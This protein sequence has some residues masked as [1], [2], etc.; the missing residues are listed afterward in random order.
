MACCATNG[1]MWP[2]KAP[3]PAVAL[4]L[5]VRHPW[6]LCGSV[7]APSGFR[8]TPPGSDDH[9][10]VGDSYHLSQAVQCRIPRVVRSLFRVARLRVLNVVATAS[11]A[12]E[13]GA[14]PDKSGSRRRQA[15]QRVWFGPCLSLIRVGLAVSQK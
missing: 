8:Q 3:D 2:T 10:D 9:E 13:V 5:L 1:S 12:G 14:E 7:A 11:K 6:M 4:L 15:G